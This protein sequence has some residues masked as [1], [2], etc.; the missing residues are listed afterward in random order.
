MNEGDCFVLDCNKVIYVYVGTHCKKMESMKAILAATQVRDQDHAGKGKIII[1]GNVDELNEPLIVKAKF[2]Y[3]LKIN[4]AAKANLQRFSRS[5]VADREAKCH[6]HPSQ[7]TTCLSKLINRSAY[8]HYFWHFVYD[9]VIAQLI[10][11][12][13]LLPI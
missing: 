11:L 7:M 12:I 6:Q 10:Y 9:F 5:W 13:V 4:S 3:L 2:Y 1:L 8:F